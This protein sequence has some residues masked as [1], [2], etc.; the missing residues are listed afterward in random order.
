[1][2]DEELN[3]FPAEY[4]NLS[5][6]AAIELAVFNIAKTEKRSIED[7]VEPF[8]LLSEENEEFSHNF[9]LLMLLTINLS[10]RVA[11][12]NSC[13]YYYCL[14]RAKIPRPSCAYG[15]NVLHLP[16]KSILNA[17]H[18]LSTRLVTGFS[19]ATHSIYLINGSTRVKKKRT[20]KVYQVVC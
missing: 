7:Y 10:S 15:S 20:V 19:P 13:I 11:F 12:Y 9:L 17:A 18:L 6:D 4:L 3:C 16:D 1:M 8:D 5:C 14:I 2:A